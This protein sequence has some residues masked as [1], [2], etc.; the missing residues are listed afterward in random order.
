MDTLF[1][2]LGNDIYYSAK[3]AALSIKYGVAVIGNLYLGN[4]FYREDG[5]I[6]WINMGSGESLKALE[7][8]GGG[9]PE[10][11]CKTYGF[12]PSRE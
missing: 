3:A 8:S 9:H 11:L 4:V 2:F 6:N 1:A 7:K 10:N 12:P 5:R